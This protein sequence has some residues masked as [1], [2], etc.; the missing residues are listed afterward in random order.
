MITVPVY[1]MVILPGITFYFQGSYF[2][3]LAGC[4]PEVGDEVLFLPLK[5]EKERKDIEA[6][7]FCRVGVSGTVESINEEGSVGIRT[8]GRITIE[9][10]D[11]MK[12]QPGADEKEG[13]KT[14]V[15]HYSDRPEEEDLEQEER[16]AR[17]VAARTALIQFTAGF[18]WG[19]IVRS[20]IMQWKT[21]G[22][23]V[24]MM[25][26]RLTIT[27]EEK[28][29][30]I[31][32]DKISERTELMEQAIYEFI[33]L[34]RIS[35]EAESDAARTNEK[36][37]REDSLKKQISFLQKELDAMH[38]ESISDVRRFELAIQDSKMNETARKEATKVL[39]RMKQEG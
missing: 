38:P 25:S 23:M 15:V 1:N 37:Y 9:S 39:N 26:S 34:S 22:E 32:A 17:F 36:L 7:D 24:A 21:M 16:N 8:V 3:E 6:D 4:D 2:K 30:I 28:Y 18:Q 13:E 31:A 33:E 11:V 14:F 20:Y 27:A 35:N 10:V 5:E 29:A 19:M 12:Q